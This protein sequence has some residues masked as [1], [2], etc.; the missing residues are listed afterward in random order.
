M[1]Y[2]GIAITILGMTSLLAVIPAEVRA[3]PVSTLQAQGNNDQVFQQGIDKITAGDYRGAIEVFNRV[4]QSNPDDVEAYFNRALAYAQVEDYQKAIVDYSRVLRLTPNDPDA[5]TNRALARAQLEDY[6]GAIA[7]YTKVIEVSPNNADA[8]YNR[9]LSRAQIDDDPIA[10]Q[11]LQRAA[12][13][14]AKEGKTTESQESL[15]VIRT[16]QP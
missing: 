12:E 10:I 2:N 8:Y 15:S 13:L 9:G 4:L 5:L 6:E 7:D 11:D 14:Y 1:N 16:L 3:T